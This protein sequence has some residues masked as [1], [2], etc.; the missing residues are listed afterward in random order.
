[1]GW[2]VY[3]ENCTSC[4][5]FA[6]LGDSK[7]CQTCAISTLDKVK[8]LCPLCLEDYNKELDKSEEKQYS[9]KRSN[10]RPLSDAVDMLECK[11]CKENTMS[12]DVNGLC[13]YCKNSK[14][15]TS[16]KHFCPKCKHKATLVDSDTILCPDC[17]PACKSCGGNFSPTLTTELY[18]E[19][20][21]PYA[22]N[23]RCSNCDV[24]SEVLDVGL[25]CKDCAKILRNENSVNFDTLYCPS[26][27]LNATFIIYDDNGIPHIEICNTC[28]E[29][30]KKCPICFQNSIEPDKFMCTKCLSWVKD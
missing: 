26:C 27:Q 24:Q 25:K 28:K 30:D 18:C 16:H 5:K 10:Y 14:I 7:I 6:L 20:C 9:P 12:L 17:L 1:M 15:T 4:G 21:V 13:H 29:R 3:Q 23:S 19:V 2:G 11:N 8:Y 22:Q